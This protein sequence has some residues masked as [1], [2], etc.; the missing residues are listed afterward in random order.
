MSQFV[1][2]LCLHD[3]MCGSG[4]LLRILL[5]KNSSIPAPKKGGSYQNYKK[6]RK[7]AKVKHPVL[8]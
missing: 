5:E 4:S 1:S 3:S 7:L 2:A 8:L 6:E